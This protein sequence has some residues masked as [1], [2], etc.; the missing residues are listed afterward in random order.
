MEGERKKRAKL[1]TPTMQSNDHTMI[2]DETSVVVDQNTDV[3]ID[4]LK[5]GISN[6]M[7]G[8]IIIKVYL[9]K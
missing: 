3:Y 1:G 7:V 2:K 8:A 6:I 9:Y 5:K 4:D